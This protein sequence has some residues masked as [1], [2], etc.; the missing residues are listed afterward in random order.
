MAVVRWILVIMMAIIAIASI[1]HGF[2]LVKKSGTA[3]AAH[4]T[5]YCPMHP[6]VVQDHPGEC[7]ICGMSLVKREATAVAADAG[8]SSVPGLTAID[9]TSE[10]VQLIGMKTAKATRAP[11]LA[12]LRTVGYVAASEQGLAKVTT[13]FA[14]FIETLVAS[15]TG[16]KVRRGELLATVYSPQVYL[17]MQEYLTTRGMGPAFGDAGDLSSDARKRLELLG[18]SAAEID[19]ID[20]SGKP[21]NTVGVF[22]PANGWIL[23]KNAVQGFAFQ[24]GTDLFTTADLTKVWVLADVY[25]S[26]LARVKVGQRAS[27][28]LAAYEGRS[29]GGDVKF[30]Y[31]TIDV[32]TRTAKIRI[33]LKNDALDL[34]PGMYGN[35]SIAVAAENALVVP[36]EA[37]VDTGEL[38]YVFV[39]ELKG[40]FVPR[41]VTTGTRSGESVEIRGGVTEGETV[42]TTGNFLLDSESRLRAAIDGTAADAGHADAPAEGG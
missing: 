31:P 8:A 29:F 39:E 22:A 6:S 40:H 34:K 32:A 19:A 24:T 9:L 25:E 33:E 17:A 20:K 30:V 23:Q 18:V 12:E 15:E 3:Q 5:W 36:R 21:K 38:Q 42:V 2:G 16:K 13:R 11:L 10:R 14:G 35:V 7:P 41:R 28:T 1:V 4:E 37:L 27:L 26:E